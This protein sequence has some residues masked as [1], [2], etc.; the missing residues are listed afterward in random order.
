MVAVIIWANFDLFVWKRRYGNVVCTCHENILTVHTLICCKLAAIVLLESYI[1]IL[2]FSQLWLLLFFEV[3]NRFQIAHQLILNSHL[4]MMNKILQ[5]LFT[6]RKIVIF[7]N[8]KRR[9]T[10][11][12]VFLWI[13]KT[14]CCT[15]ISLSS[16]CVNI[17]FRITLA[18]WRSIVRKLMI[19]RHSIQSCWNLF[20]FC[21]D[22][23]W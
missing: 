12:K 7:I 20:Y 5:L 13:H 16:Q 18:T 8:L 15:I 10:L 6:E 11:L 17:E 2:A 21:I 22:T 9:L 1:F 3:W 4:W 23:T 19:I 14:S